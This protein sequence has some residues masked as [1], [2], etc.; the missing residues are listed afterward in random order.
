V[1]LDFDHAPFDLRWGAPTAD[2]QTIG[3]GRGLAG[4]PPADCT[5]PLSVGQRAELVIEGMASWGHNA[6]MLVEMTLEELELHGVVIDTAA[7]PEPLD[8]LLRFTRGERGA[9]TELSA[10][11]APGEIADLYRAAALS[12]LDPGLYDDLRE[13]FGEPTAAQVFAITYRS[14]WT[15]NMDRTDVISALLNPPD[16]RFVEP[17]EALG[18]EAPAARPGAGGPGAPPL[19]RRPRGRRRLARRCAGQPAARR[20]RPH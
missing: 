14:A 11:A 19:G 10:E 15:W 17:G 6:G 8:R 13:A 12:R 4:P 16:L 1:D 2:Q 3:F 7:E 18:L 9:L 5:L 20:P